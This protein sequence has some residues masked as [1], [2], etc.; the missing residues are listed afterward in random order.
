MAFSRGVWNCLQNRWREENM[1]R[2]T[3]EIR[4]RGTGMHE[5]STHRLTRIT[6]KTKMT[7]QQHRQQTAD[8]KHGNISPRQG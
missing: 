1:G 6:R 5:I 2:Q 8:A 3:T 4:L 7:L